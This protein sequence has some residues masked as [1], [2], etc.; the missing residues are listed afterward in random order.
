MT[1]PSQELVVLDRH[2]GELID[3]KQAETARL[4]AFVT[5]LG[6]IR[7]E[8]SAAEGI[9]SDELVAR[10][11]REAMYTL[12]VED[13]EQR[14]EIKSQSPAAGATVY[15]EDML[16]TELDAL[17][18]ANVITDGAAARALHRRIVLELGVP[19]D[20]NPRELAQQLKQALSIEVGGVELK[21]ERAEAR[22]TPV[23]SAIA[24][25]RKIEATRAALDRAQR[26]Q[27]V[28]RRKA[29][30]KVKS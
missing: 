4:A 7:Q 12:H 18:D 26:E 1:E 13:G 11:D 15:P 5:D 2:T 8:L 9:V 16:Q 29:T 25:L 24:A 10:M 17:V 3:P 22:L 21:L 23:A 14:W 6:T 19:W 30:V 27:P 28:G 20:A